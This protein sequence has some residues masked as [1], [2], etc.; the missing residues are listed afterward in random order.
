MIRHEARGEER[1]ARGFTIGYLAVAFA[2]RSGR[3][4]KR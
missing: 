4:A 1:L 3:T 2:G